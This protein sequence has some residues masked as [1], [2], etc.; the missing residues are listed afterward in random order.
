MNLGFYSDIKVA[1]I[2]KLIVSIKCKTKT[3]FI[4]I[5]NKEPFT[6]YSKYGES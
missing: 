4:H 3:S 5:F 6:M 2:G 1:I